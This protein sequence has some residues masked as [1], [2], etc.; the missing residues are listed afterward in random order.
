[1]RRLL[2]AAAAVALGSLSAF[3]GE[4]IKVGSLEITTP[5]AREMPPGAM[6]QGGFITI[7]NTGSTPDR[8]FGVSSEIAK[9]ME[10][11]EMA[12]IDG[13]MKMRALDQGLEIKP[14]ETI[15]LK[16]GSFHVMFIGLTKA[17]KA[18]ETFK[19][20]VRFEKAGPVDLTFMVAPLGAKTPT[21]SAMGNGHA[22]PVDPHKSH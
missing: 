8:L 20:T 4:L 5:W 14:G 7:K 21:D 11:H 6:A 10:I 17:V 18:G 9:T 19:G 3:A 12:I 22:A 13:V 1:M 15:E 16:P 2:F